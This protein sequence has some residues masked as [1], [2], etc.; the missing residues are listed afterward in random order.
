MTGLSDPATAPEAR[1]ARRPARA[2]VIGSLLRPPLL[3]EALAEI[4]PREHSMAYAEE[5]AKDRSRL[6]EIAEKEIER[7]VARQVEA[8]LDVVTDGE[9]RRVLYTNSLQDAIEGL[10]PGPKR[11]TF[12]T[13]SGEE[14]ETAPIPRAEARLR[15][16][17]SPLAREA[18]LL[19][20]LTAHPFKVTLPAGSWFLSP[21]NFVP[22]LTD[23][24]YE[25][26]DELMDDV[27]GI[28]RALIA[29]AIDAGA[30]Y[31]QLDFPRYV[32]L[33]SEG[34]RE[35]LRSS[36]ADPD[37]FLER[38]L[39]VD[40]RVIE[41]FPSDITFGLHLCRGNFRSSWIYEGS[42]EP[43]AER[44]FNELPYDVFLVEWED[45]SRDGDYS[46]LRHVPPGPTVVLG[47]VSSK[48]AGLE[49]DEDVLEALE[50]AGRFL[51]ID[52][53]AL[54]TQCGFAS[55]AQGNH[56]TEDDQWRKLDLVVSVSDQVWGS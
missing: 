8:G 53:L 15:K 39:D 26:H 52:Q 38:A 35:A 22:G 47:A 16:V 33:L 7:V 49:S 29:E 43:V 13:A 42:L 18:A 9:F 3:L 51:D 6:D 44:L 37:T 12:R 21:E 27:L 32:N 46:P 36:G 34:H 4:Y 11:R 2:E 41:G 10:R 1:V 48:V 24:F 30:R 54:S 14:V 19:A 56:L 28:Q 50:E 20:Q 45:T 55:E 40:R 31:I 25:S 5:R 17:G 23:R